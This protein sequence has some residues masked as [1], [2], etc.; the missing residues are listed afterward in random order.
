MESPAPGNRESSRRAR[1]G[2]NHEE[3]H[4]KTSTVQI[5]KIEVQVLPPPLPSYRQALPPAPPKGRLARGYALWPG[6]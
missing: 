2:S 4:E 5:G 1:Q 3:T 6:W